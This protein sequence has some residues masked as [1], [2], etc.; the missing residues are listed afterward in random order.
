MWGLSLRIIVIVAVMSFVMPIYL[1]F[2]NEY[3]A[4]RA[5]IL[6]LYVVYMLF[7]LFPPACIRGL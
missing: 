4:Q 7:F 2:Y 1:K 3:I 5:Y 6:H